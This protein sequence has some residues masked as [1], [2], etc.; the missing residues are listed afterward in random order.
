MVDYAIGIDGSTL[1]NSVHNVGAQFKRYGG[2]SVAATL[3]GG[4]NLSVT[5]TITASGNAVQR[6]LA[7]ASTSS[8]ETALFVS[9]NTIRT[10]KAG[11]GIALSTASNV[12][13]VR[14]A[15]HAAFKVTGNAVSYCNYTGWSNNWSGVYTHFTNCSST[16]C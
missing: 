12:V 7:N 14:Y 13:S 3:S 11:S 2:T 9:P 5:G 1:W 10:M 8:G 6:G 16:W 4:G 15:P